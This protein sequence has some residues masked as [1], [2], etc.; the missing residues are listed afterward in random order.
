MKN[1][2]IPRPLVYV[3]VSGAEH[4][5]TNFNTW[6]DWD[7][8]ADVPANSIAIIVVRNL[9][10]ANPRQHGV[11]PNGSAAG[12]RALCPNF[13]VKADLLYPV[14]VDA[15][16]IIEIFAEAAVANAGFFVYGYMR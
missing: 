1:V 10:V 5:A 11:R 13:T 14:Q 2:E 9:D 6:E 3:E 12:F 15:A 8:S 16:G 7:I 4:T